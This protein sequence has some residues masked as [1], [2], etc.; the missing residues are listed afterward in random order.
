MSSTSPIRMIKMMNTQ[1]LFR[2]LF[3]HLIWR[4]GGANAELLADCPSHEQVKFMVIGLLNMF[5]AFFIGLASASLFNISFNYFSLRD[6]PALAGCFFIGGL[7]LIL[8]QASCR[9][10]QRGKN[11]TLS[12][13]ISFPVLVWVL[14]LNSAYFDRFFDHQGL[15]VNEQLI[16]SLLFAVEMWF[17][18]A[19]SFIKY[20]WF[21]PF[22][23]ASLQQAVDIIEDENPLIKIKSEFTSNDTDSKESVRNM[24][25]EKSLQTR[26]EKNPK[27]LDLGRK[28]IKVCLRNKNHDA[29]IQIYD[30][31][32]NSYPENF[33]LMM[34]KAALYKNFDEFLYVKT[35]EQAEKIR[36]KNS[37]LDNLGK[38]ITLKKIVIKD[39]G[40]FNDFTWEFQTGVNVLLGK[41]GYGKS[42]LLRALVV[43]LQKEED[44]AQ[45][46]F[47]NSGQNSQA[48]QNG[49]LKPSILVEIEKDGVPESTMRTQQLFEKT[50]GKVPVLA[51]PDMR[52]IEKSVDF[53]SAPND[54]MTDLKSQSAWHFMHEATYTGPI[55]KFLYDLCLDYLEKN[56]LDLPI[57][58]LVEEVVGKL[59]NTKFKFHE[60]VRKDSA[61]FQILVIT[62]GNEQPLPLQKAS[63]GTLSILAMF[64]MIYRYLKAIN[65]SLP[66]DKIRDQHAIVVIDEIDAHLHPSWQHKVLP[67]LCDIFPKVQFVVT[68]HSPLVISGRKKREVAV[69]R[70]ID[71]KFSVQVLDKHFI[72]ASSSEIYPLI[73]DVEE[74]DEAYLAL[75]TRISE[76]IEIKRKIEELEKLEEKQ[77]IT[78]TQQEELET[79]SGQLYYLNEFE[80]VRDKKE[81]QERLEAENRRLTTEIMLLRGEQQELANLNQKYHESQITD[82]VEN[83][84]LNNIDVS[85]ITNSQS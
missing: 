41:N 79:L 61:S 37:F 58:H 32:L 28:L 63:Q 5:T 23:D 2:N 46:Y 47:Y 76:K 20:F 65:S 38:S 55:T 12:V 80:L 10:L 44:I 77:A 15:R 71:N 7:A 68:A 11:S 43:I 60:I 81:K 84:T 48:I 4:S 42:H 54:K 17:I 74:K 72:G 51:I 64:G 14:L 13:I 70:K 49:V 3:L 39:L 53:I 18:F 6:I 50:F 69:L 45:Q 85:A 35:I 62:D 83:N 30:I 67:L 59:A 22:Y 75:N 21:S 16:M 78:A 52:Y 25:L 57:F 82:S 36:T 1:Y 29:A 56:S 34:E 31:L 27:D 40:F 66:E 26:F 73:F 33:D 24:F 9:V 8:L 19:P